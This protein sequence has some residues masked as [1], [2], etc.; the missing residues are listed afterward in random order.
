M[1]DEPLLDYPRLI[2]EALRDVARRALLHAAEHGLP[3]DHHFYLTFRTD[4][5]EVH[6][7]DFLR[8]QYP[9]E[10]TVVLQNQ[11]WDLVVDDWGF[12]VTLAF[13]GSRQRI[14]V[15]FPALA[16]FAD[17]AAQVGLRFE[18]QEEGE[19]E[20]AED[21]AEAEGEAAEAEGGEVGSDLPEGGG[22]EVVSL[23]S[24]RKRN[25]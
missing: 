20:E 17:P 21:G 19:G 15:P 4:A 7:P 18:P 9:G 22:G 14:G 1:P 3:G 16:A 10:M 5:D 25:D 24:F 2:A 13:E 12:S 6:V 11:Y 8:D 23:E